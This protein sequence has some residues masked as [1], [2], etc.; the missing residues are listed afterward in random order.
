MTTLKRK[1][2]RNRLSFSSCFD[3][4]TPLPG[5]LMR[6]FL[7]ALFPA[8]HRPMALF[9]PLP[10][11]TNKHWRARLCLARGFRLSKE[12][13]TH[14]RHTFTQKK[15]PPSLGV[16]SFYAPSAPVQSH[17]RLPRLHR[18]GSGK[19]NLRNRRARELGHAFGKFV[20]VLLGYGF[21]RFALR[22]NPSKTWT[23]SCSK[24]GITCG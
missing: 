19:A 6:I 4:F 16:Y 21:G 15:P 2:L 12:A 3:A 18:T 10:H 1:R 20:V 8:Q 13:P 5:F 7:S 14:V 23:L 9:A 22:R 17:G 11:Y 24:N